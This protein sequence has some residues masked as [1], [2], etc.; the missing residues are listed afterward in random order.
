MPP[1]SR[2]V[3]WSALLGAALALCACPKGVDVDSIPGGPATG[4]CQQSNQT[5]G[6][7]G[8]CC[9][10][11]LCNS[12][13]VCSGGS[14]QSVGTRC[15]SSSECCGTATCSGGV[16]MGATS[17]CLSS[18]ASCNSNAQCCGSLTCNGSICSNGSC[19]GSGQGC[20]NSSQCC[21]TLTCGNGFCH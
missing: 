9:G 1:R 5:C 12:N 7:S 13:K 16:C 18:G 3:A 21:G 2:L 19:S 6:T 20:S 11:L 8:D 17:S 4:S 14:C 10:V 15:S